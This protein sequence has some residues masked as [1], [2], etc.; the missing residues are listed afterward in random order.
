MTSYLNFF[1]LL[2]ALF[3][4]V[5]LP[6]AEPYCFLTGIVK[7][8][9]RDLAAR[10]VLLTNKQICRIADFGMAK[11]ENKNYYRYSFVFLFFMYLLVSFVFL[12][13]FLFLPFSHLLHIKRAIIFEGES[14]N[15]F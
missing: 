14:E 15:V 1:R 10:N 12:S 11:H 6:L 13:F 2:T 4:L 8:I 5:I 9:H 7:C 3:L